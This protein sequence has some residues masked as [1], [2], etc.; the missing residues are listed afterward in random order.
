[1]KPSF[2]AGDSSTTHRS[3][4]LA[5]LVIL[6]GTPM[7]YART[8]PRQSSKEVVHRTDVSVPMRDGAVLRADILLPGAEGKSPALIYRTPYGKQ[9]ALKEYKTFEKAVARVY[10]LVVQ[11]APARYAPD[12]QFVPYLIK[13]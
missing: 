12:P 9:F 13:P 6:V 7:F 1:M 5:V 8:S 10:A 3:A 4:V 2:D 11:H